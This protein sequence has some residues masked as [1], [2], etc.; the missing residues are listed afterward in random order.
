MLSKWNGFPDVVISLVFLSS[1]SFVRIFCSRSLVGDRAFMSFPLAPSFA[2]KGLL[3][4]SAPGSGCPICNVDTLC[5]LLTLLLGVGI[6]P[7]Q[8]A[9]YFA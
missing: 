1:F 2:N 6:M 5:L 7:F 8:S 4:S 9:P 3:S